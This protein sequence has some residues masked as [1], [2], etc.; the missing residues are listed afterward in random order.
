MTTQQRR[1]YRGPVLDGVRRAVRPLVSFDPQPEET[2]QAVR[3]YLIGTRSTTDLDVMEAA[4]FI[5]E[6]CVLAALG[7]EYVPEATA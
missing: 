7:G 1:Y 4:D 6:A 2:H 5:E 3:H